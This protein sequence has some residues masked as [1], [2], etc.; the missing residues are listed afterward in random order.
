[1]VLA[2]GRYGVARATTQGWKCRSRL[3]N[4]ALNDSAVGGRDSG[5]AARRK[6]QAWES[7]ICRVLVTTNRLQRLTRGIISLGP[8]APSGAASDEE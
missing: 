8:V 2:A 7:G 5:R 1:M 6:P 3:S 4:I